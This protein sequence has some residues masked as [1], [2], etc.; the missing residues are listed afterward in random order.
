MRVL[1]IG[2]GSIGKRHA[3][4]LSDLGSCVFIVTSQKINQY[5]FYTTIEDAL[6]DQKIDQII[7][8]NETYLHRDTLERILSMH[9]RGTILVE[10]PLFSRSENLM[11]VHNDIFVAYNFRFHK[12]FQYL[13]DILRDEQL[14]L[15]S[16]QVG[17][18]LPNWRNNTDYRQCYSA[19]R[20]RGGGV[21]RDLSHELDY[22]LWIC[23]KC[24]AVT[25]IGG[26]FSTLEIDS[27]DVYSILMY[28]ERC[29]VVTV[30]LDYLSR[31]PMRKITIQTKKQN[32]ILLD[33]IRGDLSVNGEVKYHVDCAIEETYVTQHKLMLRKNFSDFC[34][35]QQGLDVVKLIDTIECAVGEKKWVSV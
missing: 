24:L 19:F 3:G 26:H 5:P 1:V 7:I 2:Y 16:A 14:I 35:Y 4:I 9:F 13:R 33:F 11:N 12:L 32:T 8:A 29:P 22:V 34:D 28:C 18:Y 20:E 27:D 31:V 15:F 10:K 30:Q 23:G 21:L 25:A 6:C 17:S